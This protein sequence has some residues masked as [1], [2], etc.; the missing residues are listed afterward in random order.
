MCILVTIFLNYLCAKTLPGSI[1]SILEPWS[2]RLL[3]ADNWNE[4]NVVKHNLVFSLKTFMLHFSAPIHLQPS[5]GCDRGYIFF[6]WLWNGS[7]WRRKW[8]C[9]LFC[10][11]EDVWQLV[12]SRRS[13]IRKVRDHPIVWLN[14]VSVDVCRSI[15]LDLIQIGSLIDIPT[16]QFWTGIPKNTPSEW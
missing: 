2:S 12:S 15:L 7:G 8:W 5:R 9:L 1:W 13:P 4:Y 6:G 16:M 11:Y 14:N 10:S 3:W